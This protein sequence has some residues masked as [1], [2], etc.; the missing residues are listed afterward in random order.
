MNLNYK[1]CKLQDIKLLVAN[2]VA[3]NILKVVTKIFSDN[4]LIVTTLWL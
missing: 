1:N 2:K 3:A 4:I